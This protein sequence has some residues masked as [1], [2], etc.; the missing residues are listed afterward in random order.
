[1]P[2]HSPNEPPD[3]HQPADAPADWLLIGE[4]VG[5]FG[6]QGEVKVRPETDFPERFT[7][8]PTVY[9][10]PDH[11]PMAVARARVAP[12]GQVVLGL[13]A[14]HDATSAGKLRG[15]R[16]YVPVSEATALPP[17]QYYLHDLIGLRVQRPDGTALGVVSDVYTGAGNDVYAIRAAATGRE[18]LIPAVKDVVKRVD[19]AAGIM[20]VEPLP[21]LFDGEDGSAE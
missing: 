13:A 7:Q 16:L 8:T 2:H 9:L 15:K 18:L 21:G 6:L 14:L 12:G 1:M 20:V 17:D 10:G 11:T 4:V 5:V 19:V 3:A